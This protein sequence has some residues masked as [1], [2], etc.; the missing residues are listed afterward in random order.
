MCKHWLSNNFQLNLILS[1]MPK[2][3]LHLASI[4]VGSFVIISARWSWSV[5]LLLQL[6]YCRSSCKWQTRWLCWSRGDNSLQLSLGGVEQ[7][8]TAF[9][10]LSQATSA[11]RIGTS[12]AR[13]TSPDL[14][15]LFLGLRKGGKNAR[16]PGLAVIIKHHQTKDT[17]YSVYIYTYNNYY[18]I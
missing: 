15:I 13:A 11:V 7:K 16:V 2:E 3:C 12:W 6:V 9:T 14:V 8:D 18:K 4:Y 17:I 1:T 10:V 5:Y